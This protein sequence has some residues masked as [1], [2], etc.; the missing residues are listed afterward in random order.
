MWLYD[1]AREQSPTYDVMR[2]MCDVTLEAGY[3]AIGLYLEH[4]FAYPHAPWAQGSGA[5]D[6][7]TIQRLQDAPGRHLL[8]SRALRNASAGL[9][10][11][12]GAIFRV[13][14]RAIGLSR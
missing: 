13:N 7:R 9:I 6:G 4:R 1:I 11:A 14:R 12:G 8:Q 3:N 2:R 10:M 5:L